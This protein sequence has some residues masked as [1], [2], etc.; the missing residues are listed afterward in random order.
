MDKIAERTKEDKSYAIIS[1]TCN[2]TDPDK[3]CVLFGG[4]DKDQ[5]IYWAPD[6]QDEDWKRDSK[7]SF[8]TN[9]QKKGVFFISNKPTAA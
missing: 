5:I 3:H 6:N 9:R 8:D 1:V 4:L 2:N 7:I